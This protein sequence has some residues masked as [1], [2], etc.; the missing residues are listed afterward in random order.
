MEKCPICGKEYEPEKDKVDFG[1]DDLYK[2]LSPDNLICGECTKKI[3]DKYHYK[4]L[5]GEHKGRD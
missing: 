4:Q 3:A 5:A 2:Y 1:N